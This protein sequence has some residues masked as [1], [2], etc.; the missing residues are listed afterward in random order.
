MIILRSP[1]GGPTQGGR[2]LP[3]E[4]SFLAPGAAAQLAIRPEHLDQLE[5]WLHEHYRPTALR[6]AGSPSEELAA[7]TPEAQREWAPTSTRTAASFSTTS[8]PDLRDYAAR[9]SLRQAVSRARPRAR[10]R[11]RDV[12]EA[13]RASRSSSS[14]PDDAASTLPSSVFEATDA[15]LAG[16]TRPTRR[17][18]RKPEARVVEVLSEHL[19]QGLGSRGCLLTGQLG[20]FELHARCL[21]STSSIR[22]SSTHGDN[23]VARRI[24]DPEEGQSRRSTTLLDSHD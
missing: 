15:S 6:R 2:R 17:P 7:L 10:A 4:V 11:S 8:T 9:R 13:E 16:R 14:D 5:T 24:L 23:E 21:H 12:V 20:L 1:K 3:A 18:P 22:C 19:C